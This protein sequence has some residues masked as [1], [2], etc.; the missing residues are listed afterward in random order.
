MDCL[1]YLLDEKGYKL[2]LRGLDLSVYHDDFP[3][4]LRRSSYPKIS[5]LEFL[6]Y[7]GVPFSK[8]KAKETTI[9]ENNLQH[10]WKRLSLPFPVDYDCEE[11]A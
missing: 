5:S 10:F 11:E 4:H 8:Y 7:T 1:L 2:S 3:E 9:H 6:E